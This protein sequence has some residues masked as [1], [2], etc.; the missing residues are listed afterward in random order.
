MR[1]T[2]VV[3]CTLG[4]RGDILP[5]V[6]MGQELS[7]RGF[8][9]TIL[10]NENWKDMVEAAGLAFC[11]IAAQDPPQCGRDD[12]GFFLENTLPSFT[13]SY[14]YVLDMCGSG[15]RPLLIYRCNMLGMESAAE[16]LGLAHVKV[17]LQPSA[18]RSYERPPW[19]MT[20]L[21]QGRFKPLFKSLVVPALYVLAELS[22]RYRKHTNAFRKARGLAPHRFAAR[23]QR[24]ENATLVMAP[25]WFA[26]P[27]SDW[28]KNAHCIGFPFAAEAEAD[29]EIEAFIAQHGKPIVFTPG[30]GVQD[31]RAFF[32]SAQQACRDLDLPGIFLSATAASDTAE[33]GTR[34]LRKPF[35]D[36]N[37]LTPRARLLVH[38]GGIGTTAQALRAGVPQLVLPGRF[39][40]PDNAV[41]VASMGLGAALMKDP[42]TPGLWPSIMRQLLE[43]SRMEQRLARASASINREN[44]A[45][46][47]A[48]VIESVLDCHAV[49]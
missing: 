46:K 34:I 38:H 35:A 43:S 24:S 45:Q 20:P 32:N 25:T 48:A 16:K 14:D 11:P 41:R 5:F 17:A 19:P 42:G 9:T 4:T 31:T 3:L 10:S 27:Q 22:R 12:Y 28:P 44:A 29:A 39:D 8:V 2:H 47:A 36:L 23:A 18:I 49:G 37:W 40:Q 6:M 33:A 26:L 21:A 7:R 15:I 30:T 13:A 1:D